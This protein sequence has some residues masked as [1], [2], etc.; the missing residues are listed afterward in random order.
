M[1]KT[2]LIVLIMLVAASTACFAAN[3][4]AVG[5]EFALTN[6]SGYG[7]MLV[8]H[9]PRLPM[10]FGVGG[11]MGP[12]G[13]NLGIYADWWLAQ[14]T[15]VGMLQYYIGLGITSAISLGNYTYFDLGVRLPLALRIFVIGPVLE[16]F[17]ELAPAWIPITGGGLYP[18]NFAVQSGIGFRLWF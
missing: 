1:K 5:A 9:L 3:G 16:L 12:G 10:M 8:F 6:L 2:V 18:A 15:L 4:F 7:A 13:L 17:L 14:G 11:S